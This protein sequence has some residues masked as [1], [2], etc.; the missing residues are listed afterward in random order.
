VPVA[1]SIDWIRLTSMSFVPRPTAKSMP[2]RSRATLLRR[3]SRAPAATSAWSVLFS[4]A[5]G[6]TDCSN[7]MPEMTPSDACVSNCTWWTCMLT[8]DHRSL[9]FAS[10][11]SLVSVSW[12]QSPSLARMTSG[13][14]VSPASTFAF[15][16]A[17]TKILAF[18]SLRPDW[19]TLI[20]FSI[21]TTL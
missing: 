1:A 16:S 13:S 6:R 5:Y 3:I 7:D 21:A 9:A 12:T 20:G 19:V 4:V 8:F 17:R 18:G 10:T 15:S 2:G 14:A 11:N